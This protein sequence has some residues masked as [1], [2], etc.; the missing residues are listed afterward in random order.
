R[1]TARLFNVTFDEGHCISQWGGDDFRPE[2]KET[3]LLHWL[4]ASPNALSQATLPPLIR[5]DIRD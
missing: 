2:F 1:F 3:G 5:E 4:F